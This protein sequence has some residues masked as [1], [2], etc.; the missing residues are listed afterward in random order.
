MVPSEQIPAEAKKAEPDAGE[1]A[2]EV[3]RAFSPGA[4]AERSNA[5]GLDRWRRKAWTLCRQSPSFAVSVPLKREPIIHRNDRCMGQDNALMRRS[6]YAD[7]L[8]DAL[9]RFTARYWQLVLRSV[10]CS[11]TVGVHHIFPF[12]SVQFPIPTPRSPGISVLL[13]QSTK[14]CS[15]LVLIPGVRSAPPEYTITESLPDLCAGVAQM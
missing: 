5:D 4:I 2:E 8:V 13:Q 7:M 14:L 12:L 11:P 6:F 15:L 9:C 10:L 3:R 1:Q